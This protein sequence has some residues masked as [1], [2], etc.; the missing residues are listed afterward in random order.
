[1]KRLDLALGVLLVGG[2]VRALGSARAG[3]HSADDFL[4]VRWS[5]ENLDRP[6]AALTELPALFQHVRPAALVA[7]WLGI[8]VAS[9]Q[10]WGPRLVLHALVLGALCGV[11]ALGWRLHSRRAGLMAGLLALGAPV[12]AVASWNAWTANAGE[13]CFGL[14]AVLFA[15]GAIRRGGSMRWVTTLLAVILSGLFRESGWV[16]YPLAI[17]V[18]AWP[19]GLAR[20]WRGLVP[21]LLVASAGLV[22][23]LHAEHGRRLALS[24]VGENL[25]TRVGDLVSGWP[26]S[27]GTGL[28]ALALALALVA[29]GWVALLVAVLWTVWPFLA[30][31]TVLPLLGVAAFRGRLAPA[32]TLCLV[33]LAVVALSPVTLLAHAF[34]AGLGLA[35]ATALGLARRPGQTVVALAI[36]LHLVAVWSRP[37]PTP[38]GESA[39]AH[40]L[41]SVVQGLD[42]EEAWPPPGGRPVPYEEYLVLPLFG[43]TF[44]PAP[45]RDWPYR[46]WFAGEAVLGTDVRPDGVAAGT[47]SFALG[48][49]GTGAWARLVDGCG[50]RT[51][52]GPAA[53]GSNGAVAVVWIAP[54]CEA[55]SI[56]QRGK[57]F[58]VYLADPRIGL[59]ATPARPRIGDLP[60]DTRA[61]SVETRPMPAR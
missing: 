47:G 18:L 11:V 51:Q 37:T 30:V 21:L 52:A 10:W 58:L 16:V 56:T 46:L 29:P 8:V 31:V 20:A 14:L 1:M 39:R 54:G 55:I 6:W 13:A 53:R 43:T 40:R 44:A 4:L 42:I 61:D 28:G 12:E 3:W 25:V 5:L 45:S 60:P 7:N 24:H 34:Q 32:A 15:D 22:L 48:A 2:V 17:A 41:G 36:G 26:L 23:T 33:S 59:P 35:L 9:G 57:P 27:E 50:N 49:L 38:P 19:S